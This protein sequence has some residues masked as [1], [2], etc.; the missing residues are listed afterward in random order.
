MQWK[1]SER[2]SDCRQGLSH[3]DSLLA[4]IGVSLSLNEAGYSRRP[5]L[6]H[7]E[8]SSHRPTS[9]VEN[10]VTFFLVIMGPLGRP[11]SSK[12]N[13]QAKPTKGQRGR[14]RNNHNS[15]STES[16]EDV[17]PKVKLLLAEQNSDGGKRTSRDIE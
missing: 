1:S 8:S 12:N 14:P 10:S 15:Q 16:R 11:K 6:S 17:G 5:Y 2:G 9:T 4:V 3:L 13:K 7:H